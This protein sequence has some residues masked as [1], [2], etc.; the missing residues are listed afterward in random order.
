MTIKTKS[1]QKRLAI[2]LAGAFITMQTGFAS[3]AN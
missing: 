3:A 1:W 2:V